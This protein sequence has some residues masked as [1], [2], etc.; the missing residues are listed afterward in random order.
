MS[1]VKIFLW[2]NLVV[3]YEMSYRPYKTVHCKV[4][5]HLGNLKSF[6]GKKQET[7]CETLSI[8]KILN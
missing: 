2:F 7:K 1:V 8:N 6:K 4:Q 3:P 5:T